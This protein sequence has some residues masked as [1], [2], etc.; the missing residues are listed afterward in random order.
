MYRSGIYNQLFGCIAKPFR[1]HKL[2]L[3]KTASDGD[4]TTCMEDAGIRRFLFLNK[5]INITIPD[6][7]SLY[8]VFECKELARQYVIGRQYTHFD[9]LKK[10]LAVF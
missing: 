2:E 3:T 1:Q 5:I 7:K 8:G 9:F 10:M 4:Y 6:T